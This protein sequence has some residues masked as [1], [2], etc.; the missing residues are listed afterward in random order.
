MRFSMRKAINIKAQPAPY[1]FLS[2]PFIKV[3]SMRI[4]ADKAEALEIQELGEKLEVKSI[5]YKSVVLFY[6]QFNRMEADLDTI[7]WRSGEPTFIPDILK[8]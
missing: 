4:R 2:F 1:Y 6:W 8:E 7:L 3:F 5:N